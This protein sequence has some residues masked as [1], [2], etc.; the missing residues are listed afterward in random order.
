MCSI[1]LIG[2]QETGIPLEK[3]GCG[4]AREQGWR[5]AD[6]LLCALQH[7]LIFVPC[8]WFT[9][10]ENKYKLVRGQWI[11]KDWKRTAKEIGQKLG[12]TFQNQRKTLRKIKLSVLSNT[13]QS[14]V[15]CSFRMSI[16]FRNREVIDI[17]SG[18]RHSILSD[19][20]RLE[21]YQRRL[22]TSNLKFSEYL[23]VEE[24]RVRDGLT[25]IF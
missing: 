10:S 7:L 15:K 8:R 22:D 19:F 9:C 3:I 6:V 1:C 23:N 4:E 13:A 14:L 12:E 5:E 25:I 16:W 11:W 20:Q 18:N 2:Y 17:Q 21:D 24:L